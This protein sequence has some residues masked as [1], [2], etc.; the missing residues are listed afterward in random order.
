MMNQL[1]PV[2]KNLIIINCL[3]FAAGYLLPGLPGLLALSHVK[4]EF[5]RPYQLFT[6]MFVHGSIG[7]IFFNMLGLYFFGPILESTWGSMRFLTFYIACGIGAGIFNM[8]IDLYL[9]TQSFSTMVGASGAI[10]G[11]MTAFGILFPNMVINLLF[12]P[13]AIKAKYLVLG[14]GAIALYSAL[15][16]SAADNTAHL[17]HLGGIVVAILMLQFWR[18]IRY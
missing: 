7:H 5:F 13:V 2:V 8:L 4:S 18:G 6:Y 1:T 16:P 14:F 17:T 9:N 10:Y 3:V 15:N 12:P 11:V